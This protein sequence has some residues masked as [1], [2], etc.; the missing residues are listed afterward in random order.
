MQQSRQLIVTAALGLAAVGLLVAGPIAQPDHYHAFA[1]TRVWLGIPNALDVLSNLPFLIIG[2][3]GLLRT[4]QVPQALQL[5]WRTLSIA[6]CATFAGSAFYHWAPDDVGLLIDRIPIALA[7]VAIALMMLADRVSAAAARPLPLAMMSVLAVTSCLYWYFTQTAGHGDLRPYLFL[8]ALPMLLVPL[9]T[10]LYR[11]GTIRG[12]TWWTVFALYAAAK[13]CEVLDHQ[14][15]DALA[16]ISGHTL[17]HLFAATA[18]WVLIRT[19]F[20]EV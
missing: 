5:P 10:L 16:V 4:E 9:L 7:C 6:L 13:L 3:I 8:Q 14:M 20:R 15:L 12:S 2:I 19:D 1:D 17:K 11:G 18:A